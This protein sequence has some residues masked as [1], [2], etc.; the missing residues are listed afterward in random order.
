MANEEASKSSTRNQTGWKE[1]IEQCKTEKWERQKRLADAL[2]GVVE[3]GTDSEHAATDGEL[4]ALPGG[5]DVCS[6]LL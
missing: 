2:M 4:H 1:R 3:R 6:R 5:A